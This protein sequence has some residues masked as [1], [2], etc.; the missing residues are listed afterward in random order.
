M[1][2]TGETFNPSDLKDIEVPN[3]ITIKNAKHNIKEGIKTLL[4]K[5]VTLE[6]I[7]LLIV[8]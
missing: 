6:E 4:N 5:G 1:F 7:N 3:N 2:L 8:K